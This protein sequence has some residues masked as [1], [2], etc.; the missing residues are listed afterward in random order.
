MNDHVHFS[1][2]DEE[3]NLDA[4]NSASSPTSSVLTPS[5]LTTSPSLSG[6]FQTS[7][8]DSNSPKQSNSGH[9]SS[10]GTNGNVADSSGNGSRYNACSFVTLRNSFTPSSSGSNCGQ[11][12]NDIKNDSSPGNSDQGLFL[13]S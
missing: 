3:D 9:S 2:P 13:L 11:N 1:M 10:S 12:N 7:G 4:S 8:S 5:S 6:S